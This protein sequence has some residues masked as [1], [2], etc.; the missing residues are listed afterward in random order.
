MSTSQIHRIVARL[1]LVAASV[2]CANTVQAVVC[3]TSF[4]DVPT[5]S[6]Y[7]IA[8]EWMKQRGVTAGCS[9]AT[10][11]CPDQTVT[12]ASMALFLQRLAN[13]LEPKFPRQAETFAG[14][15]IPFMACVTPAMDMGNYVHVATGTAMFYAE[16]GG[17]TYI[18]SVSLM[19]SVDG[20]AWT[21]WSEYVTPV[22]LSAGYRTANSVSMAHHFQPHAS[23]R[24][25]LMVDANGVAIEGGC[26]LRAR[27][28]NSSGPQL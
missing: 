7:C 9:D 18:T 14:K 28:E 20:G 1:A 23:V 27:V 4:V 13:A 11:Y 22:T 2:L 25:G 17:A 26:E 6:N 21:D 16:T 8:A 24:F 15:V 19:Y 12:R 10:H 5:D 3:N